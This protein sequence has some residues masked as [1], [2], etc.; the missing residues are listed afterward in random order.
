MGTTID[1]KVIEHAIEA[2]RAIDE[3]ISTAFRKALDLWAEKVLDTYSADVPY[4]HF[5]A[6]S[7]HDVRVLQSVM[8]AGTT[9]E[10]FKQ[11]L[12]DVLTLWWRRRH[13]SDA[14]ITW[15][16]AEWDT[17]MT[18]PDRWISVIPRTTHSI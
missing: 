16:I 6:L 18:G 10:D 3:V 5:G 13:G 15:E 4:A 17:K 1:V 11:E 2:R 14:Q 7:V 8:P 12:T 9:H